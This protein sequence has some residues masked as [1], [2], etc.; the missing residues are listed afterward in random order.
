MELRY[1]LREI[2]AYK[3]AILAAVVVTAVVVFAVTNSFERTYTAAAQLVVTAGLGSDGS[4]TDD[5]I[6]APRLGQTYA[7]LATTRPILQ[8]VI[9]LADLSYSPSELAANISVTADLDTP[10]M[11]IAVVDADPAAAA[12]AANAMADVLVELATLEALGETPEIQLLR[13]VEQASVPDDPSA[14][15]VMF[16]TALSAAAA[17]AACL[18]ALALVVYIR[19]DESTSK[20]P[21]LQ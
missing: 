14:P 10:F 17:L 5:V 13:V 21:R 16:S 12:A 2:W 1:Y 3:F 7:V 15:R 9:E 20:S 11:T 4:D 8:D 6:N 19:A 18:L